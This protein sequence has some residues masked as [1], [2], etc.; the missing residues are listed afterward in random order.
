MLTYISGM[1]S[2]YVKSEKGQ[3]MVEYGLILALVVVIAMVGL[4][5]MGNDISN[6]FNNVKAQL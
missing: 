6:T 3:G 2:Q 4:V 1:L 5:G